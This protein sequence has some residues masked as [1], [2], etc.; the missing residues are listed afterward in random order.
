[1]KNYI[2]FWPDKKTKKEFWNNK[3]FFFFDID[4]FASYFDGDQRVKENIFKNKVDLDFFNLKKNNIENL[5]ENYRNFLPM[6]CRFT[7]KGDTYEVNIRRAIIQT[8]K[9][10]VFLQKKKINI[11]IFYT[12]IVHHQDSLIASN[13]CKL[14][15]IKQIFFAVETLHYRLLPLLENKSLK[16]NK[17]MN[18]KIYDI[19]YE[20]IIN[21]FIEI[22]KS[23][24][25][26]K[27]YNRIHP[28]NTSILFSFLYF[29]FYFSPKRIIYNFYKLLKNIIDKNSYD[30]FQYLDNGYIFNELNILIRHYKA[31]KFYR[32]QV[33][34]LKLNENKEDTKLIFFAHSQP[35]SSTFPLGLKLGNHIDSI[36]KIR[37][38]GYKKKIFYKEHYGS[39][40][41]TTKIEK[42]NWDRSFTRT[43]IYRTLDYYRDILDL[44]CELTEIDTKIFFKKESED[45]NLLPI[46]IT[47][48]VALQRALCGFKTIIMGH[49]WW[50]KIPGVIHISEIKDFNQLEHYTKY[51]NEIEQEAKKFLLNILNNNTFHNGPGIGTG[52]LSKTDMH[53][54]FIKGIKLLIEYIDKKNLE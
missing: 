52:R 19:N 15:S 50:S 18:T 28:E 10:S 32:S 9:L 7:T 16:D 2:F 31:N 39:F 8:I 48:T 24:S 4:G 37:E 44:N 27:H 22:T 47:G 6:W 5:V 51:S 3:N 36:I 43:G 35:E 26:P 21:E 23:G 29:F 45:L 14:A 1:M 13:S 41:Y 53:T 11:A 20:Q 49:I 12:G 25:Q 34:K 30:Q 54:K 42:S 38:L 40:V 17:F 33:T 46:T